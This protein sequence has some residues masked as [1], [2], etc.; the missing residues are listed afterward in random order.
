MT[1]SKINKWSSL[2]Y[3]RLLLFLKIYFPKSKFFVFFSLPTSASCRRPIRGAAGRPLKPSEYWINEDN[4][5]RIIHTETRSFS[6]TLTRGGSAAPS[7]KVPAPRGYLSLLLKLLLLVV[8]SASIYYVYQN[9]ND[10]H[11]SALRGLVDSVVVPLQD[12]ANTAATYL[13]ISG[14]GAAGGEGK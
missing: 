7:S 1:L 14:G 4:L 11:I 3:Y 5:Q 10:D 6:E 13:G 9:L 12:A 2:N 8:V